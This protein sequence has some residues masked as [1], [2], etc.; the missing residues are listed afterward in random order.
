[1]LQAHELAVEAAVTGSRRALLNAFLVDPIVFSIEDA[2]G[3][4]ESML[5]AER[6][7]LPGMWYS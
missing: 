3:L 6:D 5:E 7:A 2:R 4:I 1:M